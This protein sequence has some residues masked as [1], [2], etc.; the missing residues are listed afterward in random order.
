LQIVA[1]T[2]TPTEG[3]L[4]TEGRVAALL[5]LGSGFNPEFTGRQNTFFNGQI[6]GLTHRQ[7]EERFDSIAEFAA[8]GHFLDQ[9]V[10]TY[11]SGMIV[12][13][14]FAIL[15]HI[16]PDILLVD[17]A[18]AVGDAAFQA[19]CMQRIRRMK[20]HGVTIVFVSHDIGNVKMLCDHAAI[21][22]SGRLVAKGSPREMANRYTA[23]LSTDPE[24]VERFNQTVAV[25]RQPAAASDGAT[26]PRHGNQKARILAVRL[27][28]SQGHE[29][30]SVRTGSSFTVSIR[31]QRP[32]H[33]RDLVAGISVRNLM[34]L[35]IYGTNT[36]LTETPVGDSADSQIE[37][38]F[39]FPCQMNRGV[40]TLTA[41]LHAETGVSYDWIDEVL[42]F[43]VIN[44]RICDGL[45]D[46]G[47]HVS[48]QPHGNAVS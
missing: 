47:A 35:V 13:L 28:D 27:E 32:E 42:V 17:E 43:E 2:V 33:L 38:C 36:L 26:R 5:E 25:E 9:P 39:T 15:V 14:A 18:L 34:G 23:I 11:S 1:G 40:Y 6:I 10:K 24:Q 46:L 3:R 29:I 19:K 8:I 31:I 44:E 45:V 37:I 4:R 22:D 12:R 20:E 48:V 41:G 7:I 21:L 16:D 30:Q